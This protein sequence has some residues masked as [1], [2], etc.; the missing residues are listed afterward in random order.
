MNTNDQEFDQQTTQMNTNDQDFYP[1]STNMNTNEQRNDEISPT[2]TQPEEGKLGKISEMIEEKSSSISTDQDDSDYQFSSFSSI[3]NSNSY[4]TSSTEPNHIEDIKTQGFISNNTSSKE[5][6]YES[7]SITTA[8]KSEIRTT[9]KKF[10]TPRTGEKKQ[11]KP[12]T[13]YSKDYHFNGNKNKQCVGKFFSVFLGNRPIID[14][15]LRYKVSEFFKRFLKIIRENHHSIKGFNSF[16]AFS[17]YFPQFF[18]Q[19]FLIFFF[20][21]DYTVRD[22]KISY[23]KSWLI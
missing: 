5:D 13:E 18:N 21:L 4:S 3:S 10:E 1:R 14:F 9:L 15:Y 11:V 2:F 7:K 12:I 23:E 6:I 17:P 8:K 16:Q 19:I 20:K 22:L